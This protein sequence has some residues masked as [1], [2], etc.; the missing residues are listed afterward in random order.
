MPR[1]RLKNNFIFYD[2]NNN[3]INKHVAERYEQ[4]FA[5]MF[6]KENDVVLE[7]G[8]RYGT[9]SC[10]INSK[11]KNK[12][13]QVSVEP[14]STVWD[15]IELNK[16]N[17]NCEFHILKGVI[18][19]K[20]LNLKYNGYGSSTEQLKDDENVSEIYNYTLEDI[21][22]KYNLNFNVLVADCEGFLETFMNEN[23]NLY[24]ELDMIMFEED[25]KDICNYSQIKKNLKLNG[26][27]RI[28]YKGYVTHQH[29][30]SKSVRNPNR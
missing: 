8:A 5:E 1:L 28:A 13:S 30:Y 18:S 3:I 7:L 19:N 25:R 10:A 9:V 15:A 27:N 11:L 16:N 12:K 24:K 6:I 29:V 22:K 23:P 2:E 4:I 21:K 14:D 26:F 20:K 17:N